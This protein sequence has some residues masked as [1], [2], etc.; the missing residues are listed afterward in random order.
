[1]AEVETPFEQHG[2]S[3]ELVAVCA[4]VRDLASAPASTWRPLPGGK[5]HT[6]GWS[7][8]LLGLADLATHVPLSACS[9]QW[10]R[11][12]LGLQVASLPPPPP[13]GPAARRRR[14]QQQCRLAGMCLCSGRGLKL[15]RMRK[16]LGQIAVGLR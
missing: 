1:M 9:Q 8:D 6:L 14:R 11:A 2:A 12:H 7:L 3:A 10:Q 15:K 16:R 4:P 5:I 13:L